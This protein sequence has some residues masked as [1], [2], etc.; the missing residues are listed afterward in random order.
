[1]LGVAAS[2]L[3]GSTYWGPNITMMQKA[4]PGTEFGNYISAYQFT[5][6]MA[7]CISTAAVGSL[8]TFMNAG[9]N[10]VL[11]GRIIAGMLSIGYGGSIWAW[12]KA[13]EEFKKNTALN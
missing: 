3:L 12:F 7:A 9:S 10:P 4:I 1:M 5:I 2:F 6:T 8:I 13:R 11:I